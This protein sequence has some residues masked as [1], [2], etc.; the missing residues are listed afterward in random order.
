[1]L[2]SCLHTACYMSPA[3]L[4]LLLLTSIGSLILS[5]DKWLGHCSRLDE[6]LWKSLMTADTV[7]A[8]Q[9]CSY[10]EL[11]FLPSPYTTTSRWQS[12]ACS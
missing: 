6:A 7:R 1:M 8:V 3:L 4:L 11:Y 9:P 10:Q 5:N 12:V 2:T